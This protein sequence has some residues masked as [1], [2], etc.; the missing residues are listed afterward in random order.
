MMPNT[1]SRDPFFIPI[2]NYLSCILMIFPNNK[3]CNVQPIS[4]FVTN[5]FWDRSLDSFLLTFE[6]AKQETGRV[7]CIRE[8]VQRRKKKAIRTSGFPTH[9]GLG[10]HRDKIGLK[11]L[12]K[13]ANSRL[14]SARVTM[15][16]D[17]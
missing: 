9:S 4:K 5:C 14:K 2:M 3:Q 10:S 8:F 12:N 15:H 17:Q 16:P 13:F 1:E 11:L 7:T 6:S